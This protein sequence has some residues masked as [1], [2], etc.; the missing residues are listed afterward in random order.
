[1]KVLCEHNKTIIDMTG[2]CTQIT[3]TESLNEGA[4]TVELKYVKAGLILDNGDV[5]R[6]SEKDEKDGI[7][8]GMIFKVSVDEKEEVTIKAYDQLRYLKAK[9]IVVLENP[10]LSEIVKYACKKMSLKVGSVADTKLKLKTIAR[11]DKT[12]LDLISDAIKDTL[13]ISGAKDYYVL[14]ENYGQVDLINAKD[15]ELPLVLGNGSLATSYSYEKSID[16]DYYNIVKI[17]YKDEGLGKNELVTSSDKEAVNRF[18]ILQYLEFSNG[19]SKKDIAGKR[20]ED[21]LKLYN[22]EKESLKLEC[23]GDFS[24]RAGNSIYANIEDIKLGKR[25]IIK[26]VTHKFL[27]IHT[28]SIEV[29]TNG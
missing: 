9:D 4:S 26:S 29:I 21:L 17:L 19:I 13:V 7:F 25:L 18:G 16:D 3:F 1:M 24:I 22:K 12:Y 23:V 6:I 11:Y 20:A 15:L 2:T 14:R 5:I 10:T 27:P 8:F 28:M